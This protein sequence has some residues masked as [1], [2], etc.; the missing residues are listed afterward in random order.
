MI[1]RVTGR[2]QWI[3]NGRLLL[4]SGCL[5][6]VLLA[7]GTWQLNR[8]EQKQSRLDRWQQ[9]VDELDWSEQVH[10][11]LEEGQPVR[12]SGHYAENLDWLLDNRTRKGVPGYE[13]LTVFYPDQGTPLVVNRGW[14]SGTGD[15]GALPRVATPTSTVM[16]RGRVGVFPQPPVL[17]ESPVSEGW[18]RRVQRLSAEQ[19]RTQAGLSAVAGQIVRLAGP[20]QPGAFTAIWPPDRM[21]PQRHTGYAIQWYSLALAVI[22]LTLAFSYRKT[23][24]GHDGDDD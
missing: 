6:P 12:V 17:A 11:G 13:V 9:Q 15:R 8:A 1:Q 24:K 14:I 21:T 16:I 2:R 7:L 22:G 20:E 19:A 10:Q 18:P 5:L 23:D 4:F 3:F